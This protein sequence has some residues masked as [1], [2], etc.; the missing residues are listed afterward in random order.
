M[1]AVN[2]L[3]DIRL[4]V[5]NE[6]D[7][8]LIEGLVHEAYIVLFDGCMLGSGSSQLWERGEQSFDSRTGNF[9]E[10]TRKYCLAPAGAYRRCEDDL[11]IVRAWSV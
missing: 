8:Q 5:G 4:A 3:K 11:V 2:V 10:L 9:S 1:K 6:D 7:I